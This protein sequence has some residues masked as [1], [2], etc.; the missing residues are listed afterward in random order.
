MKSVTR[1]SID[2]S[3][4][5]PLANC[6]IWNVAMYVAL[7]W[8]LGPWVYPCTG[9]HQATLCIGYFKVDVQIVNRY[10]LY[11]SASSR[12]S[13]TQFRRIMNHFNH[14]R[15]IRLTFLYKVDLWFR[16]LSVQ[17]ITGN[18]VYTLQ[19]MSAVCKLLIVRRTAI[20]FSNVCQGRWFFLRRA[21]GVQNT[22][23][24]T[25]LWSSWP[26]C[27]GVVCHKLH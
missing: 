2:S 1:P 17:W 21:T 20:Q 4:N 16:T 7:T 19:C 15:S 22:H 3:S 10:V 27:P 5:A 13:V 12:E 26:C 23:W 8:P 14:L 11:S 6:T 24:S 9:L 25:G 18:K